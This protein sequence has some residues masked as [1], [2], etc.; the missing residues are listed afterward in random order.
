[1]NI[2]YM[3]RCDPCE[4][5]TNYISNYKNHKVSKPHIR[6]TDN[7]GDYKYYCDPCNFRAVYK[8]K[9]E[10][11]KK[12]KGHKLRTTPP[13]LL[14]C[15][16]CG[17]T[18]F[19]IG[20]LRYHIRKQHFDKA[21]LKMV[22]VKATRENKDS[23]ENDDYVNDRQLLQDEISKVILKLKEEKKDPND[24]FNYNYYCSQNIN[25]SLDELNDFYSELKS[26]F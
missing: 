25:L 18:S 4:Y 8:S 24:Y 23:L 5:S 13:K 19:N 10:V 22:K 9:W 1:M 12:S 7:T 17:Y 11:H 26:I 3:Y 6:I 14:K 2:F 16:L 21:D 20:Y 15:N